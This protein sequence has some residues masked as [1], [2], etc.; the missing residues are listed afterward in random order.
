MPPLL[1]SL[2]THAAAV[3]ADPS[4]LPQL[5]A[6][7]VDW[8]RRPNR[9]FGLLQSVLLLFAQLATHEAVGRQPLL[10]ALANA[11][12]L[13]LVLA[14]WVEAQPDV[15]KPSAAAQMLTALLQICEPSCSQVI[16]SRPPTHFSHMFTPLF[17]Y[18]TF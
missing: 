7:L 14:L 13:E 10:N 16:L 5:L 18:L 17:P 1:G 15:L 2:L 11:S 8:L 9:R 3:I 12:A 4:T 6:P